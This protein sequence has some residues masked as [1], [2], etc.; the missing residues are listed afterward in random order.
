[1]KKF[2]RRSDRAKKKELASLA[3]INDERASEFEKTASRNV[4][5]EK[6]IELQGETNTLGRKNDVH[7]NFRETYIS[8]WLVGSV[9]ERDHWAN[10]NNDDRLRAIKWMNCHRHAVTFDYISRGS[11]QRDFRNFHSSNVALTPIIRWK[12]TR[13]KMKDTKLSLAMALRSIVVRWSFGLDN[14]HYGDSRTA[15]LFLW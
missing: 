5:L 14:L 2:E 15:D 4:W 3:R 8:F 1:M 12:R 7:E 11:L 10:R 13:R 9:K 6:N